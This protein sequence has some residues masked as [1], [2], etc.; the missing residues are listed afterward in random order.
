MAQPPAI[1]PLHGE[2]A[3]YL[4]QIYEHFLDDLIRNV[5]HLKGKPIRARFNP[6]TNGKGFSFWHVISEGDEENERVPDLR[7]CERIRWIA[8]MI[9]QVANGAEHIL[10][11]NNTRTSRRG[12]VERLV[13]FCEEASYAV[14]L[15]ERADHLLL[16]SAYPVSGRRAAKLRAEWE[17]SQQ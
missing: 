15:E 3:D 5:R 1:I 17:A 12:T 2:W 9:D 7:R 11:W 8:W 13:L 4:D 14:I 6:E 16:V 10:T